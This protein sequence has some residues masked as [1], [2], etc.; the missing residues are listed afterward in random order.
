TLSLLDGDLVAGSGSLRP[1]DGYFPVP[2]RP[3]APDPA[4]LDRYE[5]AD[6][7]RASWWRDRL[8]RVRAEQQR[9]R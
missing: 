4:L 3:P 2:C 7:R 6:P 1:V 9:F 8:R 5:L